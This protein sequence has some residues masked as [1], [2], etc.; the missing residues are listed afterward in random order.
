MESASCSKQQDWGIHS[1]KFFCS[2]FAKNILEKEYSVKIPCGFFL[3]NHQKG[4]TIFFAKNCD[5]CLQHERMLHIFL[6]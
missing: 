3:K 5:N 2:Y 4:H 6:L 1:V